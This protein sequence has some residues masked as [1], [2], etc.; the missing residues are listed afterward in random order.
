MSLLKALNLPPLP[1]GR[2]TP[3]A[4]AETVTGLAAPP[5]GQNEKL[6]QAAEAWRKT[7]RQADERVAALKAAIKAQCAGSPAPLLQGLDQGLAKLDGVLGTVDGRLADALDRATAMTDDVAR[8]SEL[9]SA[10]AIVTQY[11][12]HLKAEPLV[13]H[14]DTNPFGVRTGLKSMLVKALTQ[15]AK[16]VG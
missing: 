3:S 13:A 2:A 9:R 16:A 12:N 7:H 15:V 14:M 1:P 5:T 11:L 10:K 8:Q 6:A 4:A